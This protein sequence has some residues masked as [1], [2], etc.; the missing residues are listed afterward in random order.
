MR[1]SKALEQTRGSGEEFHRLVWLSLAGAGARKVEAFVR[2]SL[3]GRDDS[4]V[5]DCPR[6]RPFSAAQALTRCNARSVPA[7]LLRRVF[8]SM[9]M[10]PG[11]TDP[12]KSVA[13]LEKARP[14]L[15]RQQRLQHAT[16]GIFGGRAVRHVEESREPLLLRLD[17]VRIRGE[18]LLP[19][20]EAHNRREEDRRSG[21]TKIAS[22][23]PR[24]VDALEQV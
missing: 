2:Q 14:R 21:V 8:P 3:L 10:T 17:D 4:S 12:A 13:H 18:R 16:V 15:L 19:A 1:A 9:A 5:A 24:V 23:R 20:G 22:A 11:S 7:L 6:T